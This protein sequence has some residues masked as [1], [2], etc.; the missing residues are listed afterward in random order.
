MKVNISNSNNLNRI[1]KEIRL[2]WNNA[3][4][5]N[6]L[7]CINH[8]FCKRYTGVMHFEDI[9]ALESKDNRPKPIY[10]IESGENT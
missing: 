8:L 5:N 1:K 2:Y 9:T 6:I 3:L 10:I 4:Q 7:G